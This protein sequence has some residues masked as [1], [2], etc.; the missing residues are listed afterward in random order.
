MPSHNISTSQHFVYA[1][2]HHPNGA[3]TLQ[4]KPPDLK[5]ARWDVSHTSHHTLAASRSSTAACSTSTPPPATTSSPCVGD[6]VVVLDST[7]DPEWW[8]VRRLADGARGMVPA[9]FLALTAWKAKDP[10]APGGR[11]PAALPRGRLRGHLRL[12]RGRRRRAHGRRR[13]PRDRGRAQRG[14]LVHRCATLTAPRVSSPATTWRRTRPSLPSAG[15]P[16]ASGPSSRAL[17]D[18]ERCRRRSDHGEHLAKQVAVA[19]AAAGNTPPPANPRGQAQAAP[20]RPLPSIAAHPRRPGRGPGRAPAAA[21][22][23]PRLRPRPPSPTRSPQ[24]SR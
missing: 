14:R 23:A 17:Q 13:R 11:W 22:A 3:V 18:P 12:R 6:A 2:C 8:Q 1:L 16:T 20:K 4:Q 21:P 24:K 10:D 7:T 15:P 19:T 9:N 5:R